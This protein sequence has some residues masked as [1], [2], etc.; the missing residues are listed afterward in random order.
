MRLENIG[1]KFDTDHWGMSQQDTTVTFPLDQFA[2]DLFNKSNKNPLIKLQSI[3]Y[4]ELSLTGNQLYSDVVSSKTNWN[5]NL[6]QP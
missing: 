2:N 3:L 4:Q 5:L 6:T 1:D